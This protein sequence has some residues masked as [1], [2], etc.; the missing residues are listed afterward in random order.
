MPTESDTGWNGVI[1]TLPNAMRFVTADPMALAHSF[2][3]ILFLYV[4]LLIVKF[5]GKIALF[6]HASD[7]YVFLC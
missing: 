2:I 4:V 3:R 1:D 7:F 5:Y 6:Y